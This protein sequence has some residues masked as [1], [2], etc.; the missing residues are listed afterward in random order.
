MDFN[1][2]EDQKDLILAISNSIKNFDDNYWLEC[3]NNASFPHEF[4]NTL[5]D[6]GWLGIAMPEEFGGSNL[7]VT[8]SA[9]MMMTIAEKGA[10]TAASS[11]HMNIFG[12]NSLVKFVIS[13]LSPFSFPIYS[14]LFSNVYPNPPV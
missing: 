11:V 10:M 9:L 7:G 8:E 1:Y 5:A 14:I 13:L 4:V 12:P 2:T 3:D 6:G